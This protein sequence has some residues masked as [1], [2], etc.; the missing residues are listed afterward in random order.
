MDG[1]D[2]PPL[3]PPPSSNPKLDI[4][5]PFYLSPVDRPGDFFTP[6]RLKHDNYDEWAVDIHLALEARH[7][8]GFLSGTIV[9][10]KPPYSSEDLATINAMLI[11]WIFNNISPN[12]VKGTLTKFREPKRLW[13]HLQTRFA[14][15]NGTRIQQLCSSLARCDQPKNMSVSTYYGKLNALWDELNHHVPLISCPC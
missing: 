15:V 2:A 13:D 11:S 4:T 6:T 14:T 8:F 9:A 10:A 3:P 12:V 1:E 7:K 5:F